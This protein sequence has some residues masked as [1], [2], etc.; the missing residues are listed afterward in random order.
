MSSIIFKK[1]FEVQ[2]FHDYFLTTVDGISFFDKSQAEKAELLT[3]KLDRNIYNINDLFTIEPV[4]LTKLRLR[5][6]KLIMS[7]TALGFIVGIEVDVVSQAGEI[8]YKPR[9]E[10]KNEVN[11]SFAITSKIPF[12]NSITNINLSSSLPSIHYFT[13]KGKEE[14]NETVGPPYTSLP[15]SNKAGEHQNGLNYEM[16]ALVDFGGTIKEALQYTDGNTPAH[17]VDIDDK[18]FVNNSD[19]ILLPSNFNYSLKKDQNITQVDFILEDES[20]TV[21]KSISKS[22]AGALENVFLNF[23]KVDETDE[24]SDA[25][26]A[27]KYQLKIKE[28]GG[29]E[30]I[31]QVYLNN[32][33]YDKNIQGV[34]DIRLDELNSPFSLFDAGGF[35]KTKIDAANQKVSHPIFEIRFKN[36]RTYWRYNKEGDFSAAEVAATA[37]H[38]NHQS[39]KLISKKPKALTETL[40][41]F[42]NGTSL[43]LPHPRMPSIKVENGNIFSEIFINQSN[44]LLNN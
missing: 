12:F 22:S 28:N 11:L 18:R 20:N 16:G 4:G 32:D 2:I 41:P 6:Y 30:V 38:L 1:L 26:P 5:E 24:N 31:Y 39:E 9:L 34:I 23:T 13:N 25:I 7:K 37:T 29:P 43:M 36:R 35:L 8:L 10:L 21:I 14:F 3:K 44:R 33:I 17:W 40:V 19:K 15:I 27:G 42:I